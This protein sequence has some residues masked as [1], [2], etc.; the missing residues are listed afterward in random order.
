MRIK[1]KVHMNLE[2]LNEKAI[3]NGEK[4]VTAK[5]ISEILEFREML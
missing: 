5:E 2:E 1:E 3:E 4:G